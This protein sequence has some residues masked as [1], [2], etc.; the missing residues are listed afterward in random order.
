MPTET[1]IKTVRAP[2]RLPPRVAGLD[3]YGLRPALLRQARRVHRL[4]IKIVAF[5]LG[6]ALIIGLWVIHEWQ[7]H[8]QFQRFAHES[9]PGDWNPT[10]PALSIGIWGLWVGIAALRVHFERPPTTSQIDHEVERLE[11]LQFR[12][13]TT[14][15]ERLAALRHLAREHLERVGRLRFHISAWLLGMIIGIPLSAL[16]EWQDNGTFERIGTDSRP[17]S[18]DPWMLSVG[19][20]WAAGIAVF[21][22]WV[23]VN[24]PEKRIE[25]N[26]VR[27]RAS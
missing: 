5:V 15:A 8:G 25:A 18:W 11:P 12:R 16:I 7:A 3:P 14:Q 6:T 1:L 19:A 20:V 2:S 27:Y 9:N 22:I 13:M 10:L 23:H 21:A 17:G 24:R 26:R 4:K